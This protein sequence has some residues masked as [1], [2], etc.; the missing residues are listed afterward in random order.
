M[1]DS[2]VLAA[3]FKAKRLGITSA[4]LRN[5][6]TSTVAPYVDARKHASATEVTQFI[7][8]LSASEL[9]GTPFADVALEAYTTLRK[10]GQ[11]PADAVELIMETVI[12]AAKARAAAGR[13]YGVVLA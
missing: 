1:F 10:E 7:E 13:E 2:D 5:L 12:D 6:P 8:E 4:E 3:L 11:T 9:G